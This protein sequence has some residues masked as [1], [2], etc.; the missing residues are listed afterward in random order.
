LGGRLSLEPPIDGKDVEHE[1]RLDRL[2]R[3]TLRLVDQVTKKG[4]G[5]VRVVVYCGHSAPFGAS[6]TSIDERLFTDANGMF[7]FDGVIP[8]IEHSV[9][10]DSA[11]WDVP[12]TDP[13]TKRAVKPNI[14]AFAVEPGATHDLGTVEISTE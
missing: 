4:V 10:V 14:P 11:P 13:E 3:V 1:I 2:G 12:S 7:A 9:V 5:D 8:G 6:S